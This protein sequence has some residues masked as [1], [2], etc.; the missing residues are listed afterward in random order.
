MN[1]QMDRR[2]KANTHHPTTQNTPTPPPPYYVFLSLKTTD[3]VHSWSRSIHP[4]IQQQQKK[5]AS[6]FILLPVFNIHLPL[7]NIHR[8]STSF[9]ASREKETEVSH[10]TW[11]QNQTKPSRQDTSR[12]ATKQ[13]S[14]RAKWRLTVVV[15]TNVFH[16]IYLS[17]YSGIEVKHRFD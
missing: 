16:N 14:K 5:E 9:Y 7:V 15:G 1:E 13:T 3:Y 2:T 8:Y 6:T 4:S 11:D 17:I 12:Q 10:S